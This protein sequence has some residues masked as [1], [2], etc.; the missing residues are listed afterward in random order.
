MTLLTSGPRHPRYDID[1]FL[2]PLIDDL[3]ILWN[4]IPNCYDKY[5]DEYFTLRAVLLFTINDY[6]VLCNS[7]RC[8]GKGYKGYV[9]YGESTYSRWLRLSRKPC[10]MGHR[11]YLD[12]NHPFRKYRKSLNGDQVLELAN[13]SVSGEE[14]YESVRDIKLNS[15]KR[16]QAMRTPMRTKGKKKARKKTK[17]NG[18]EKV[19]AKAKT[20]RKTKT[21]LNASV[22]TNTKKKTS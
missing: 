10:Y 14:I 3:K 5:K 9:I 12:P 21:K 22:N 8:R 2:A 6:P 19:K 4:G 15:E 11:W 1:V 16:Y 17:A 7:V 18:R 13:E 20:M